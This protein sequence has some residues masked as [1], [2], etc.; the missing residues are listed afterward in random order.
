MSGTS[1]LRDWLIASAT[2]LVILGVSIA[3]FLVP[4]Y[5]RLEQDRVGVDELTGYTRPQLDTIAG[6]L[7][8]DLVLWRGDF[9]VAFDGAPVLNDRERGHMR[10]VRGVFAGFFALV[11]IAAFVLVVAARRSTATEAK[12]A[13]WRAV[14]AGA[15]ALA[16]GLAVAGALTILAFDAAFELFHRLFFSSGT[17]TFDPR[18]DRLVQLFPEAFWSETATIVGVLALALAL[19]TLW[20]ARRHS[21][22]RR[23][24]PILTASKART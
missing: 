14:S 8:T 3:P 15:R 4:A 24:T 11:A 1:R 6:S 9:D 21:A 22:S 12:F 10:D 20:Q 5:I 7:I 19:L 13:L 17:Y 2:S 23:I 18:T 16:V